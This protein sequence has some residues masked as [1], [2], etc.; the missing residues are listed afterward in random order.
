M[1]GRLTAFLYGVFCYL[2][3]FGTLLYAIGFIGNLVV[4][5]SIDAGPQ[6]SLFTALLI[7]ADCSACCI[8]HSVMARQ[9]FSAP[10]PR[11]S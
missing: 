10:D 2:V 11:S 6:G 5:K 1:F 3:F 8:Q 4:P 7:D 9:W